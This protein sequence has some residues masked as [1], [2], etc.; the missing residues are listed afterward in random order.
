MAFKGI[1]DEDTLAN[2]AGKGRVDRGVAEL[3][4][5]GVRNKTRVAVAQQTRRERTAAERNNDRQRLL[6]GLAAAVGIVF[7]TFG[8]VLGRHLGNRSVINDKYAAELH[9]AKQNLIANG[10]AS[11][12]EDGQFHVNNEASTKD[13][14]K[15]GTSNFTFTDASC[16]YDLIG[17]KEM[18]KLVRTIEISN[19]KGHYY[20]DFN[21]YCI[22][23]GVIDSNGLPDYSL[24][25]NLAKKEISESF[26]ES[27]FIDNQSYYDTNIS[28]PGKGGK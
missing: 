2:I 13:Y 22:I 20:T 3:N 1:N 15:L 16:Y 10:L 28:H 11:Y 5:V 18:D 17:Y 8:Y 25:Y 21:Q 14:S 23:N 19:D 12:D 6:A 26:T 24:L 7:G 9:V 27:T 4:S